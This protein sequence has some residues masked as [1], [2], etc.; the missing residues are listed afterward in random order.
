MKF[1]VKDKSTH[2]ETIS[3]KPGTATRSGFGWYTLSDNGSTWHLDFI[4]LVI[5]SKTVPLLETGLLIIIQVKKPSEL[6]ELLCGINEPLSHPGTFKIMLCDINVLPNLCGHA[7]YISQPE[8]CDA[9]LQEFM[10][11]IKLLI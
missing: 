1:F 4:F 5:A 11:C 3:G 10:N 6:S 9:S 8:L 2:Q 7:K